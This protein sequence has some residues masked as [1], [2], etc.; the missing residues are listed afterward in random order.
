MLLWREDRRGSL[1]WDLH[2]PCGA[3]FFRPQFLQKISDAKLRVW[4]EE[5]HKIWRKLG[6]KVAVARACFMALMTAPGM[7]QSP[8][9]WDSRCL[10]AQIYS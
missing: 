2:K 1:T 4:A 9:W 10:G 7:G 5:L 3:I 6:R 8:A